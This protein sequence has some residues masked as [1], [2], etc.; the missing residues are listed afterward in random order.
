[1]SLTWAAQRWSPRPLLHS[2]QAASLLE[3]AQQPAAFNTSGVVL[4]YSQ[5]AAGCSS[6]CVLRVVTCSAALPST[7][8]QVHISGGCL[9][10]WDRAVM[11]AEHS[12]GFHTP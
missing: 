8:S 12:A 2:R 11:S 9:S 5:H 4:C 3:P 1:L 10:Q 6:C 7:S